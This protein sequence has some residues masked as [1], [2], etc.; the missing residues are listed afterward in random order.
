[1]A[2]L[3]MLFRGTEY[4]IPENRAFEVGA[5]VEDVALFFEIMGWLKAPHFHKMSRCLGVLLRAAGC[6]VDDQGVYKELMASV[7]S[8]GSNAYFTTALFGLVTLLMDGAPAGDGDAEPEKA[9]G[10]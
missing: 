2:A 8:A 4:V 1:M 10:L 7:R 6:D 9:A 3:R 5:E